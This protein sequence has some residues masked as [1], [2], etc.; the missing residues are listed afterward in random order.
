M[1]LRT[2]ILLALCVI[3]LVP[4][5]GVG[6]FAYVLIHRTPGEYFESNGARIYYTV[7]G[8]GE[9][10]ILVHGI[11]ANADWNWQR[12]GVVKALAKDF[13]VIA[14]DLRGHGMTDKPVDPEQYGLRMVEDIVLLM[15]H[16]GY[17][18]AHLAGYSLGGFLALKAATL[19]PDRIASLAVC[20][21]GW[22]DPAHPIEVPSPYRP[23]VPTDQL[24]QVSQAS[25]LPLF[26]AS[27]TLF[28]R[29]R[30]A[31]G[32]YFMDPKVKKALKAKYADLGV[33]KEDLLGLDMPMMSIIGS[34]DGFLYIARDLIALKPEIESFEIDN[35]G[36]F[37]LPFNRE[38]KEHLRT[39]F[40][41]HP[42][43][44]PGEK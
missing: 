43:Q 16:L 9:P 8:K 34:K 28:H 30:S 6:G 3:I 44:E 18:R 1:R 27:K 17:D 14:F 37:S 29:I 39:F 42:I 15:D 33:P 38:F 25:A 4:C 19:Y 35:Y 40:L 12:P 31:V 13:T 36:H 7:Q 32:D 20:A 21:A 5:F 10:V 24:K 2:K 23:P 26:A 41:K 11:G 22:I